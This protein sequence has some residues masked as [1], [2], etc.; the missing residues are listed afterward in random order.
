MKI[1]GVS[2]TPF[3]RRDVWDPVQGKSIELAY[4]GS[5]AEI[6]SLGIA[7]EG[8]GY[9]HSITTRTGFNEL[10]VNIPLTSAVNGIAETPTE[11][12][13]IDSNIQEVEILTSAVVA[14]S[15]SEV[16]NNAL[17]AALDFYQTG[18]SANLT[19]EKPKF[20]TNATALAVYNL[21][22]KG[23][24][25]LPESRPVLRYSR[26]FSG[27]YGGSIQV[28]L[29][30]TIYT[31]ASLIS[32][33]GVP[34]SIQGDLPSNPSGSETPPYTTWAWLQ[35][36]HSRLRGIRSDR[37]NEVREWQFAPWPTAPFTLV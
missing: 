28:N 36:R 34:A 11:D 15:L 25:S 23:Y 9:R 14:A 10:R 6:I 26:N 31:T 7:F 22:T 5:N 3:D 13:E 18:D 33:F 24:D 16:E 19:V 1:A 4:K 12:W 30:R 20:N 32:T 8:L 27:S 37:Y 17:K 2:Q 29:A 35:T 21:K